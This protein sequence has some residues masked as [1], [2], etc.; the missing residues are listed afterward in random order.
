M[1]TEQLRYSKE[2]LKEFEEL[3]KEKVDKTKNNF[4]LELSKENTVKKKRLIYAHQM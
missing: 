1:A 3:L 2:E 4:Q